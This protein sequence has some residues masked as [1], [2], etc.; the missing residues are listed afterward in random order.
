MILDY[1][2]KSFLSMS[3]DWG[4][5]VW[6]PAGFCPKTKNYPLFTLQT[7]RVHPC[8]QDTDLSHNKDTLPGERRKC[9]LCSLYDCVRNKR[10]M[11]G[12]KN[13]HLFF[14]SFCCFLQSSFLCVFISLFFYLTLS[15]VEDGTSHCCGFY[16]SAFH[17][18]HGDWSKS[19][20]LQ[21]WAATNWRP[22]LCLPLGGWRN[23]RYTL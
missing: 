22:D 4:K 16:G 11:M 3:G 13:L 6:K 21:L 5:I 20:C 19:I 14:L 2:M 8:W 23:Q 17:P 1:V 12:E 18:F 7:P 9:V 15:C 10:N